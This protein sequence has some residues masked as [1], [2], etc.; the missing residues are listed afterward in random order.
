MLSDGGGRLG[1][2]DDKGVGI[3]D[4]KGDRAARDESERDVVI[5]TVESK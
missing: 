3:R 2:A 4:C 5:D 1:A